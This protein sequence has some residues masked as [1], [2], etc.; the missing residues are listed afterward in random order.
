LLA[1]P[2]QIL[3]KSSYNTTLIVHL[4]ECSTRCSNNS[5]I[6]Q[7]LPHNVYEPEMFHFCSVISRYHCHNLS[8]QDGNCTTFTIHVTALLVS[9]YTVRSASP[10]L[11]TTV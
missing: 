5:V 3:D 11:A 6:I 9:Q 7:S 10:Q 8:N 2:E 1:D 4:S